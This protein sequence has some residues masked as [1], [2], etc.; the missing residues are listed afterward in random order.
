[1]DPQPFARILNRLSRR[2]ALLALLL[3]SACGGEAEREAP[4]PLPALAGPSTLLRLPRAG[5]Q[6]VAYIPEDLREAGWTS[7][8]SV[9]PLR[10][11]LGADL[12]ERMVLAVDT[13]GNLVAV[14]LDTRSVRGS[15]VRGVV[16]ATLAGDGSVYVVD[17]TGTV[18]HLLRRMPTRFRAS[19]P[20]PPS[21]LFGALND[22][23]VAVTT[24]D[25]PAVVVVEHDTETE[26]YPVPP[27][28]AAATLWADLLAI[29]AD[30]AVVFYDAQR[31][32][33][34]PSLRINGGARSV[35]FSP[36]GDRLYVARNRPDLLVFDRFSLERTATVELP[37][38]ASAIR[39][40]ASGRWVMLRA[41]GG[42]S[43]DVVDATVNRVVARLP[44][45][46]HEDLPLVAGAATLI[47]R[48]GDSVEAWDLSEAVPQRRGRIAGGATDFWSVIA[49]VPPARAVELAEAAETTV[50]V[51][52]SAIVFGVIPPPDLAPPSRIFLQVSSSQNAA[53]ARELARQ[54]S[55]GGFPALVRDPQAAD[56][57]YR[58]LLGPYPSREVAEEAGRRLGRPYFVLTDPGAT[59]QR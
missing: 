33:P 16:A 59:E 14:E 31:R 21:Q 24:G 57:G 56:D 28:E 10:R 5:G 52:D 34:R 39:P 22:R 1:M 13:A 30:T 7:A 38:P 40:D 12:D 54:L 44:G 8:G 26:P 23:L 3:A 58:V 41:E 27:G 49:W 4:Q 15:V 11:P 18:T 51:Q 20:G 48:H 53:W 19:L 42:D 2:G 29:A 46:W 45:Q 35:A 32:M 50:V 25:V 17:A 6:A 55:G 36:S 9:G 37:S 47:L 43:I